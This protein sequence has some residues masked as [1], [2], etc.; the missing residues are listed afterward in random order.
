MAGPLIVIAGGEGK[1]QDFAPLREA[2]R[3]KVRC[4]VLI[5]RDAPAIEQVLHDV[6]PTERSTSMPE[7]VRAA[8]QVAR[9]GDTVLLSPACASLDM[10]RNYAHRGDVFAARSGSS[11]HERRLPP[12]PLR[13]R[14]TARA[15]CA[16]IW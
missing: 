9:P 2:F 12:W 15:A 16:S 13:N 11:R 1:S 3:G 10:F 4:V 7:A 5:G 8:A 6:C 14:D